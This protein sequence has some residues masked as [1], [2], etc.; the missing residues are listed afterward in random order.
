MEAEMAPEGDKRLSTFGPVEMLGVE[1]AE[2]RQRYPER[3]VEPLRGEIASVLAR[4]ESGLVA[5]ESIASLVGTEKW[6]AHMALEANPLLASGFAIANAPG[7]AQHLALSTQFKKDQRGVSSILASRPSLPLV[8][9]STFPPLHDLRHAIAF[10]DASTSWGAMGWVLVK[11]QLHSLRAEWPVHVHA[12]IRAGSWSISPGEAWILHVILELLQHVRGGEEM[13]F[14]S[15]SDNEAAEAV[16]NKHKGGSTAMR[17]IASAIGTSVSTGGLCMRA[18]RVT[19]DENKTAD[20]GS[21]KGGEE[22][23]QR[24]ARAMGV[25]HFEHVLTPSDPLWQLIVPNPTEGA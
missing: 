24:L 20:D 6:A 10:Q 2:E 4:G 16:A 12:L 8:P 17:A 14:S 25:P 11:G 13:F 3:K 21:R 15:F 1:V 9:R 19:T 22:A 7:G 18:L 23:A 5:R